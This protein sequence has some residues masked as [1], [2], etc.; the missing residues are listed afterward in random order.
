MDG[1]GGARP[2]CLSASCW[3]AT[4][5]VGVRC[6]LRRL[7][8]GLLAFSVAAPACGPAQLPH[9]AP[10]PTAAVEPAFEAGTT[11]L[12]ASTAADVASLD[13]SPG[14]KG[15]EGP[16]LPLPFPPPGYEIV[17]VSRQPVLVEA[18]PA[19]KG[20]IVLVVKQIDPLG[21]GFEQGVVPWFFRI[22]HGA[23]VR[24]PEMSRSFPALRIDGELL[25]DIPD[26]VETADGTVWAAVAYSGIVSD[27]VYSEIH[28][29]RPG[30]RWERYG[31]ATRR[32]ERLSP[33]TAAG[34][35]LVA[36]FAPEVAGDGAP[37]PGLRVLG[38]GRSATQ[39]P[40]LAPRE[41]RLPNRP[42]SV[43]GMPTGEVVATTRDD[44]GH[45]IVLRYGRNDTK[46]AV[47]VFPDVAH[48]DAATGSH[49]E[50]VSASA[51]TIVTV[52]SGKGG[53]RLAARFAFDGGKWVRTA[54]GT[55]PWPTLDALRRP[56][57][58]SQPPLE[59]IRMFRLSKDQA[60]AV[61]RLPTRPDETVLVSN[62]AV[63]SAQA[64]DAAPV[65]LGP[66]RR[67]PRSWR[68]SQ[69]HELEGPSLGP[70]LR[71]DDFL[72]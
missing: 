54:D 44:A 63:S 55:Q 43:H 72:F 24:H 53:E 19:P 46:P 47:Q 39:W 38:T 68:D 59:R 9:A 15:T 30:G 22:E 28:R 40:L 18:F 16:R 52:P 37:R 35:A 5:G 50:D 56:L 7:V 21:G 4:F 65:V 12:D 58:Q 66:R 70:A 67:I 64:L 29:F 2:K 60:L 27:D 14:R 71:Y 62:F 57:E 51:M 36:V 3:L 31:N 49:L 1:A 45:L 13:A 42:T 25:R 17:A 48:Y 26:I 20:P 8:T 34:T 11:A 23:L 69:A 61:G 32:T 10:A 33:I 41:S 6:M